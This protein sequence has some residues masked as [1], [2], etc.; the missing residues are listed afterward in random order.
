MELYTSKHEIKQQSEF[1]MERNSLMDA[2]EMMRD[3]SRLHIQGF[4]SGLETRHSKWWSADSIKK[5]MNAKASQPGLKHLRAV[6]IQIHD[7]FKSNADYSLEEDG[8]KKKK[9]HI[10]CQSLTKHKLY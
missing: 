2:N 10:I 3:K 1:K 8:L 6:L 4:I 5:G 9:I 7:R